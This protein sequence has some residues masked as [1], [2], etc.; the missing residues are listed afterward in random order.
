MFF[1]LQ[2][3][4]KEHSKIDGFHFRWY[5]IEHFHSVACYANISGMVVIAPIVTESIIHFS[6]AI[7]N[8]VLVAGTLQICQQNRTLT[9]FDTK[10]RVLVGPNRC[11]VGPPKHTAIDYR[12]VVVILR[13][14]GWGEKQV[15]RSTDA[16]TVSLFTCLSVCLLLSLQTHLRRRLDPLILGLL[17]FLVADTQ[18]YKRLCPSVR[19]SVGPSVRWSVRNDR[20]EKWKNERF[21]CFLCM[22]VCGVGVRVWIWVGCP[23]PPV[24]NDIVTPRHL[25][26]SSTDLTCSMQTLHLNCCCCRGFDKYAGVPT[27]SKL[28][29]I[30][31][32]FLPDEYS[33]CRLDMEIRGNS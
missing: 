23:C 22:F 25:F 17:H 29:L 32:G 28:F 30:G 16:D 9:F 1:F 31:S 3:R 11:S 27:V 5:V 19:P 2:R 4:K 7:E 6:T 18:L 21:G 13:R 15:Q 12:H 26:R 24:R 20:V 33:R 10:K 8:T 14:F